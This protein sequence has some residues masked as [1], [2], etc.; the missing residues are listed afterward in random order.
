M[1]SSKM[2]GLPPTIERRLQISG[3]KMKV[4]NAQDTLLLENVHAAREPFIAALDDRSNDRPLI[5]SSC[6]ARNGSPDER[7]TIPAMSPASNA[8]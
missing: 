4:D 6:C 5:W 2:S 1:Q 8:E 7:L 3:T